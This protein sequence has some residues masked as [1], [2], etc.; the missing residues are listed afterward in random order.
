MNC[1]IKPLV[2]PNLVRTDLA[3]TSVHVPAFFLKKG[4]IGK[5]SKRNPQLKRQQNIKYATLKNL[6]FNETLIVNNIWK[7]ISL[8]R[9]VSECGIGSNLA[10]QISTFTSIRLIVED[11]ID[12][13]S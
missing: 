5:S 13:E 4:R 10:Q 8:N 6:I 7:I 1:F 9:S 11:I 12:I 3:V 2:E